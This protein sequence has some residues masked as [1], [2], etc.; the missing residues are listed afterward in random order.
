MSVSFESALFTSAT[1]S[2]LGFLVIDPF[3]RLDRP[4]PCERWT[5]RQVLNHM[6]GSAYL[7]ASAARGE[8]PAPPDW[9]AA[10]DVLDDD[11]ALAYALAIG[12]VSSAFDSPVG[13]SA[14]IALPFATLPR[15]FALR[16]LI[17]DHVTH[18]WDLARCTGRV[19]AVDDA[20]AALSLETFR[21]WIRPELRTA[22]HFASATIP[23][24]TPTPLDRVAA[25][26]GRSV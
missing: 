14:E 4:S 7:F 3:D 26:A 12:A 9:D 23:T 10:P 13:R 18:G 2:I 22:G 15:S 8:H 25:F 20:V 21:S 11:P 24:C 17:A 16:L 19:L 1:E 5:G 6:V